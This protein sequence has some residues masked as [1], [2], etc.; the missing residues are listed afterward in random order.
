M[1]TIGRVD[2][3]DLADE[4][5]LCSLCGPSLV[6]VRFEKGEFVARRGTPREK[7]AEATRLELAQQLIAGFGQVVADAASTLHVG[8]GLVDWLSEVKVVVFDSICD[9]AGKAQR[10]K[11]LWDVHAGSLSNL[12]GWVAPAEEAGGAA[13]ERAPTPAIEGERVGV[14]VTTLEDGR[15]EHAA[16]NLD[17]VKEGVRAVLGDQVSSVTDAEIDRLAGIFSQ[18][19]RTAGRVLFDG[20]RLWYKVLAKAAGI[21]IPLGT[22]TT[23]RMRLPSEYAEGETKPAVVTVAGQSFAGAV[24]ARFKDFPLQKKG[25]VSFD[26][27]EAKRLGELLERA[28]TFLQLGDVSRKEADA[29]MLFVL[30]AAGW[31]DSAMMG[32][33]E[34]LGAGDPDVEHLVA[35]YKPAE[36]A[37]VVAPEAVVVEGGAAAPA[38][39]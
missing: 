32:K 34:A 15:V 11:L 10:V 22:T 35:F 1:A 9:W 23:S 12:P 4:G 5:L 30:G 8:K 3:K 29:A 24:T 25:E 38:A 6:T 20:L 14:I 31:L 16:D 21:D 18:K 2:I 33:V 7:V 17:G 27:A 28:F 19:Y 36:P 26:E 13:V 39:V 37:I